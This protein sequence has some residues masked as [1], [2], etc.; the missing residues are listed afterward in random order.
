MTFYCHV[1]LHFDWPLWS[2]QSGR[3]KVTQALKVIPL[4]MTKEG[5]SSDGCAALL[6]PYDLDHYQP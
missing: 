2:Y 3:I 6:Q 1:I 4:Y 5:V